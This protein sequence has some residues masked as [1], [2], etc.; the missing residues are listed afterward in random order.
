MQLVHLPDLALM[1]CLHIPLDILYNVWPP[2]VRANH[3]DSLVPQIIVCFFKDSVSL[4]GG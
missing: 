4:I 2:K 3:I 1:A